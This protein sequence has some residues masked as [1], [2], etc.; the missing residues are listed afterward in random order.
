MTNT[1]FL[2]VDHGSIFVLN[3]MSDAAKQWED[4]NLPDD[5]VTWCR[6]TV[7]E[8][9]YITDILEGIAAEGLQVTQ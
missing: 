9:R 5:A 2:L 1:D 7:I 6:G 8:P 4:D 3:A